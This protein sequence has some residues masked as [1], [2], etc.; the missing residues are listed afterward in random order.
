VCALVPAADPTDLRGSVIEVD[1]AQRAARE[2]AGPDEDKFHI[3]RSAAL[4]VA[5]AIAGGL[6]GVV[7]PT[8]VTDA[9]VEAAAA[10]KRA[11]FARIDAER[12][13]PRAIT[14]PVLDEELA[15]ARAEVRA[16][17]SEAQACYEAWDFPTRAGPLCEW[18]PFAQECDGYAAWVS[19]GR[20]L[21]ERS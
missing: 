6:P 14:I 16:I 18:C 15:V 13:R 1:L 17:W 9:L 7:E 11:F 8:P 4:E 5:A 12:S 20:P 21:P 3:G 19:E 2:A 10:D